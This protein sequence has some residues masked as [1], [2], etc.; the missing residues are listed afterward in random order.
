[1]GEGCGRYT[2]KKKPV[3]SGRLIQEFV[4]MF[5]KHERIHEP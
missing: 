5:E 2:G 4:A 3:A 1:V